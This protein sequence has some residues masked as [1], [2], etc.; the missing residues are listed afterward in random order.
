MDDYSMVSLSDSRN[1]WCARLVN[2][3]TPCIIEGLKSIF[4]EAWKLCVENDEE[5]KYLMTF[6]T[7]LSRIPQWNSEIINVERKR[8]EETSSC[9][10]LEELITCVH[11]I[12]LKA[13]TCVRVG[14][15]QKKVNIDIPSFDVFIHKI[16]CNIARKLYTNIYLFEKDIMPLDIQRNNRE[17][18]VLIKECILNTVRDTMPVENILKAYMDETEELDVQEEIV[19]VNDDVDNNKEEASLELENN[20]VDSK[21]VAKVSSKDSVKETITTEGSKDIEESEKL[22]ISKSDTSGGEIKISKS[23]TPVIVST[24]QSPISIQ[25]QP[26][27]LSTPVATTPTHSPVIASPITPLEPV[28][29][30]TSK[31]PVSSAD[32]PVVSTP[33]VAL[34]VTSPR[35]NVN[36]NDVDNAID[37]N[38]TKS[39][40]HA[41][42]TDERLEKIAEL[43]AER[44]RREEEEEEEEDKIKIGDDI[45]LDITD[46]NDLNRS[47]SIAPPPILDDIE[48]LS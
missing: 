33:T 14:Q 38:G 37:V 21:T 26:V 8:I 28:S 45:N 31:L 11:I 25:S 44:R 29:L 35:T 4:E 41:P 22:S 46:V 1:E 47:V 48:V 36:F 18:E 39:N 27:H 43:S 24:D 15:K 23:A 2:T 17:L 9:G 20:D 5:D 42:K 34:S 13:L 6:Q 32:P 3:L 40:I 16:Y 7:F 30:T 19:V 12:H 10:Y